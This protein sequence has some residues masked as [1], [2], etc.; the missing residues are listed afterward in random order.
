MKNRIALA[1]V[2]LEGCFHRR[3]DGAHE[4]GSVQV[5]CSNS[6]CSFSSNNR[7]GECDCECSGCDDED[8]CNDTSEACYYRQAGAFTGELSSPPMAIEEMEAY[9]LANYPDHVDTSCGMHVHMSFTDE[10]DY[11]RLMYPDFWDYFQESWAKWA[12][13]N[14]HPKSKFWDRFAGN[15]RYCLKEFI[16]ERQWTQTGRSDARYRHLNFCWG[17][18]RTLECRLLPMFKHKSTAVKAINHLFELVN[19]F[20]NTCESP[21][22]EHSEEI[23]V[24]AVEAEENEELIDMVAGIPRLSWDDP[25]VPYV[26]DRLSVDS[27]EVIS[28]SLNFYYGHPALEHAES[29]AVSAA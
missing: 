18:H 19:T 6:G 12:P 14:L 27:V 29:E 8:H 10:A 24:D 16:P 11:S 25:D 17:I 3:P 4:D 15:N 28:E 5:T 26:Y 23:D 13:E 9:V 1:G 22:I 2:E 20:L 21:V 7:H